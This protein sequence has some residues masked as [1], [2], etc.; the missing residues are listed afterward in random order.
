MFRIRG[1]KRRKE[2]TTI[3]LGGESYHRNI[4]S[5]TREGNSRVA[6]ASKLEGRSRCW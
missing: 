1:V 5:Y 2:R 4:L 6:Y 3:Q